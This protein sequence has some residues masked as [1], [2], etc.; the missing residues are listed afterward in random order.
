[1]ACFSAGFAC[2]GN[3]FSHFM[4][5]ASYFILNRYVSSFAATLEPTDILHLL[6]RT[7]VAN[8]HTFYPYVNTFSNMPD[9]P[10]MLR[11]VTIPDVAPASL[12][13]DANFSLIAGR[14]YLLSCTIL[15]HRSRRL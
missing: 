4:L 15:L 12:P 5:L 13:P 9:R 14:N 7:L 2:Q 10:A 8:E 1:M 11:A 3:E 6:V